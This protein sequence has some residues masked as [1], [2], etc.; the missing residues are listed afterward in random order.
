MRKASLKIKLFKNIKEEITF[1][2]FSN[3]NYFVG[4]NA[5]GKTSVL[6]AL[7]HLND[8]VNSLKFLKE[9][10]IVE[11]EIEDKKRYL[12]YFTNTKASSEG[13]LELKIYIA[14]TDDTEKGANKADRIHFMYN[15]QGGVNR[16]NLD[17]LNK[18]SVLT[19]FRKITAERI[20]NN[21]DPWSEEV[22]KRVFKTDDNELYIDYLSSGLK[23]IN[24]LRFLIDH[25]KNNP[26]NNNQSFDGIILIIEEPE[27][28]LH[29]ELQ[30]K[31]PELI[32]DLLSDINP[33]ILEKLYIFISTHSPFIIGSSSNYKNQKTYILDKGKPVDLDLNHSNFTNGYNS[34]D[35]AWVVSNMLGSKI[36]DLG[37]PENYCILEE[38]SLQLILDGLKAKNLI[39]NIQFV[40]A[41]GAMRVVNFSQT[42]NELLN[43]NTLI[44]CNPYYFDKYQIIIDSLNEFSLKEKEKIV[45]IKS[46]I[47]ER[48]I[49]LKKSS[50]EDY[51]ENIDL[52]IHK[53][54]IEEISKEKGREKGLPK[55]KYANLIL[56]KIN[57]K[58]DFSKL[59]NNELDFLLI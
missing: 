23:Q 7:S 28:N 14:T 31:V 39:R 27:N 53:M 38:Y 15:G 59:F 18:T 21:D 10:S 5:S 17:F 54:A 57:S 47:G 40:S 41:S 37:Y 34:K 32:N 36:T 12:K 48:F 20:I 3:V 49:E 46:N 51:Y 9:N 16:E 50:L 22:G 35:C 6:N 2:N 55:S 43:L 25:I 45:K 19:D 13:N 1:N 33:N 8:N 26:Q 42:I 29:P 11:F 24:N 44:K 4:K 52:D 56:N 58:E 30:K